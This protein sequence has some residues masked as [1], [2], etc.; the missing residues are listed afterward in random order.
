MIH[1]SKLP[2]GR[3]CDSTVR[4][5]NS[6]SPPPNGATNP[7]MSSVL[8]KPLNLVQFLAWQELQELRYEFDGFQAVAMTGGTVAHDRITFGLQRSLDARLAGKWLT[9]RPTRT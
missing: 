1:S 6:W 4:P 2:S 3:H 8:H 5:W 9:V 7:A